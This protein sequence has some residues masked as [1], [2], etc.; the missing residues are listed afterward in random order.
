MTTVYYTN[1]GNQLK[2]LSKFLNYILWIKLCF[3][4]KKFLTKVQF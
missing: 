4:R 1:I 3:A 2:Q